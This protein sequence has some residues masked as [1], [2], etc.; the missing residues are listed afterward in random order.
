MCFPSKELIVPAHCLPNLVERLTVEAGIESYYCDK[1]SDSITGKELS[2]SLSQDW[3]IED[4]DYYL[5][6]DPKEL[7]L[8]KRGEVNALADLLI[9]NSNERLIDD[10]WNN[11]SYQLVPFDTESIIHLLKEDILAI[12]GEVPYQDGTEVHRDVSGPLR[13]ITS[14]I[15]VN[16]VDRYTW[17]YYSEEFPDLYFDHARAV[18]PYNEENDAIL[19]VENVV[20][21]KPIENRTIPKVSTNMN[22]SVNTND[23]VIEGVGKL[24]DA[25]SMAAACNK[26]AAIDTAKLEVGKGVLLAVN[27]LFKPRV[28]LMM[29][30]V[31]GTVYADGFIAN[32]ALLG[33][34]HFF[35][36]NTKAQA[37]GQAMLQTAYMRAT[38]ELNIQGMLKEI[39]DQVNG[40]AVD[41]V[42]KAFEVEN[43]LTPDPVK[44]GNLT[45][46]LKKGDEGLD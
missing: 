24:T 40:T 22:D 3:H 20:D 45:F 36:D 30:G 18:Y 6:L 41:K 5:C 28:P 21:D 43:G 39:L 23:K 1:S 38:E 10:L 4:N 42:V 37:I 44:E 8:Y 19:L 16:L 9:H 25:L 7:P 11:N 46:N 34:A 15:P 13:T 33:F 27:E 14:R 29:R 12:R 32:M 17:A 31:V 35:P 2:I 26:K